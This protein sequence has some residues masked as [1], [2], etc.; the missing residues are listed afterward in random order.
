MAVTPIDYTNLDATLGSTDWMNALKVEI[1]NIEHNMVQKPSIGSTEIISGA[2]T[3]TAS[4]WTV[5]HINIQ[6]IPTTSIG[7]SSGDVWSSFGTLKII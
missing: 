3:F 4:L 1:L 2:W 7:I 6:N 5:E